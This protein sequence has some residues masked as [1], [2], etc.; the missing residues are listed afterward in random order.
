MRR[1]G[2]AGVAVVVV[3]GLAAC[4]SSDDD[5][6]DASGTQL[7]VETASAPS[8]VEP[9]EVT[10]APGPTAAGG[11]GGGGGEDTTPAPEVGAVLLGTAVATVSGGDIP[12]EQTG[13]VKR[14]DQRC[15]GVGTLAGLEVGAPVAVR[16]R[17]PARPSVPARSRPPRPFRSGGATNLR[18]CGTA[19]SSSA[20]S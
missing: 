7:P 18:H 15:Y 1:A 8:A 16:D 20:S 13:D 17:Q 12:D 11:G 14:E 10:V 5:D 3:I 19:R 4:G 6:G 9:A 2:T